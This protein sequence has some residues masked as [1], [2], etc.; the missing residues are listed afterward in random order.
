MTVQ[1]QLLWIVFV[2]KE[3]DIALVDVMIYLGIVN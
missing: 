2:D 1:W 3:E